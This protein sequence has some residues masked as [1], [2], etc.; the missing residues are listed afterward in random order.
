MILTTESLVCDI[1]EKDR[2]GPPMP[3]MPEY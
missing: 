3:Q 1:P 2:M